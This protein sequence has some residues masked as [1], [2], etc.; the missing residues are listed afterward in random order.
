MLDN[1]NDG[2]NNCVQ[3]GPFAHL[4]LHLAVNGSTTEYCLSRDFNQTNF[5][6]GN[7]ANL[8]ACY[9]GAQSANFSAAWPCYELNPHSAGHGTV[10]GVVCLILS[11]PPPHFFY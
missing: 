8:D 6:Q 10:K 4:T 5:A 1:D 11:P 3:D 7:Q 2:N 9:T